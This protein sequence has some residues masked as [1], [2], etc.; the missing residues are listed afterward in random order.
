MG[1]LIGLLTTAAPLLVKLVAP[2]LGDI[3]DAYVRKEITKEEMNARIAEALSGAAAKMHA[4][5]AEALSSTFGAFMDTA[6]H[7]RL[8]QFGWLAVLVTQL[9]T[10][11]W[12]QWIVPFGEFMD[13]WHKYPSPGSTIDW[14]YGLVG[15]CIG[16]GPFV[17]KGGGAITK[18]KGLIGR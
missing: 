18:L 8:M 17:L 4:A 13:W 11:F 16:L 10:L 3:V 14:A 2:Q 7:S 15:G 1:A 9:W 6:R 5:D 12:Y